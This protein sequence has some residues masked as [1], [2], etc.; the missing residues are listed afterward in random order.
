MLHL[1]F[2]TAGSGWGEEVGGWGE[3]QG[4]RLSNFPY[5][6][7]PLTPT[8]S[9]SGST[10]EMAAVAAREGGGERVCVFKREAVDNHSI[11]SGML[12]M[13]RGLVIVDGVITG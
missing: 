3:W 8:P 2:V 5:G 12:V 4:H 9:V 7:H 13:G 10:A 6:Y 11:A 1:A